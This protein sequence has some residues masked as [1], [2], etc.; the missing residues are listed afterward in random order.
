MKK[1]I[2]IFMIAVLAGSEV[3]AS[4]P[5]RVT[6]IRTLIMEAVG[7][8]EEAM[9]AVGEVIRNR[10]ADKRWPDTAYEVVTQP[11]QFSCNNGDR[12]KNWKQFKKR[13]R[14]DGG[15]WMRASKAWEKS[16]TSNITKGSN[17]YHATYISAPRW[18]WS[19]VEQKAIINNHV[20]YQEK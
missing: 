18:D 6:I 15:D 11:W 13:N 17:L 14:I 12:E 7:D 3:S 10:M 19:K 1:A 4:G 5:E 9:Q 16:K 2:F 8:G 20:F